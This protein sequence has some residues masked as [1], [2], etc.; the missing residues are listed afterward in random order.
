MSRVKASDLS[1]GDVIYLDASID[2][3]LFLV[4]KN[5]IEKKAVDC[6]FLG[7][8][9]CERGQ[10]QLMFDI[11]KNDHLYLLNPKSS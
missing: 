7:G 1:L 9:F 10:Y 6:Y 8:S 5:H 4:V 2:R 3:A 11:F